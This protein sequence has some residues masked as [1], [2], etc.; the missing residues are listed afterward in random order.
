[1]TDLERFKKITQEMDEL[2]EKKNNNYGNSFTSLYEKFG[3]LSG[4][5]PLHNKLERVTTL[6]QGAKNNFESI[7][8]TLIDL[9][10]YSVMLLVNV[11]R[12]K[13]AKENNLPHN[14]CDFHSGE[15]INGELLQRYVEEQFEELARREN[16]FEA[17]ND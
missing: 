7:E 15:E 1:M 12:E 13:E 11:R 5:V 17:S 14:F 8:D 2:F 9:A 16:S 3:M 6:V 4:L 10:T